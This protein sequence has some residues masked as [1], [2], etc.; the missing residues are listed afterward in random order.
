[1]M[2]LLALT[3]ARLIDGVELSMCDTPAVAFR[4]EPGAAPGAEPGT[5]SILL[6]LVTRPLHACL[7]LFVSSFSFIHLQYAP[8]QTVC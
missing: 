1:M 8:R 6:P 3:P 5:L 4:A 7:N 2:C